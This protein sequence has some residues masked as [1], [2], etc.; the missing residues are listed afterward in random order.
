MKDIAIIGI[1]LTLPY[2][3][4]LE[5]FWEILRSGVDCL[6]EMPVHRQFDVEQ[7]Y[8]AYEQDCSEYDIPMGAYL[9]HVDFF[10][11]QFFGMNYDEAVLLEPA[12]RLLFQTTWKAIEDAGY[13]KA[14]ISNTDTAIYLGCSNSEEY[15]GF[16]ML[17]HQY[18]LYR[19]VDAESISD[20]FHWSGISVKIN[21][22]C[23][24]S[25]VAVHQACQALSNGEANMAIAGGIRLSLLP[26]KYTKIGVESDDGITR[27]FDSKA[28]GCGGGEGVITILLKEFEQAKRDKDYIHAVIKGS[29]CNQDGATISL[30]APNRE[31]QTQVIRSA[32][33]NAGI[34][35]ETITYIEAHGTGTELGDVVEVEGI[36]KAF[37]EHT[38]CRQ[39][40]GIGSVKSNYGHMEAAAGLLGLVKAVLVLKNKI[41]PPTLHFSYPNKNILFPMTPVYV[42]LHNTQWEQENSVYR[43][44]VSSF[45]FTGTNTHVVL[46]RAPEPEHKEEPLSV[47]LLTISAKD[48]AVLD[49]HILNYINLNYENRS[50]TDICYTANA[51]RE[52]YNYRLA[53]IFKNK[54]DLI[55]KLICCLE[56]GNSLEKEK[57]IYYGY[58]TDQEDVELSWQEI[59]TDKEEL[60]WE[61]I[62]CLYVAGRAVPWKMVYRNIEAKKISLF[63]Y[64]FARNRCWVDAGK[65]KENKVARPYYTLMF[66]ESSVE[67]P[68]KTKVTTV[69]MLLH[70]SDI[71]KQLAEFLKKKGVFVIEVNLSDSFKIYHE[72]SFSCG[73]SEKDFEQL[74]HN[75]TVSDSVSF[76][77]DACYWNKNSTLTENSQVLTDGLRYL[78]NFVKVLGRQQIGK[79]MLNIVTSNTFTVDGRAQ[80]YEGGNAA[81]IGFGKAIQGE[82]HTITC[83]CIDTDEDFHAI[84]K[85]LRT[86]S[87][88]YLAVYRKGKRYIQFIDRRH[89]HNGKPYEFKA[90][91]VYLLAGGLGNIGINIANAISYWGAKHIA[92]IS[93]RTL[94]ERSNWERILQGSEQYDS[95]DIQV[96]RR[97]FEIEKLG[98]R[99]HLYS[100]D[101]THLGRVDEIIKDCVSKFGKIN[102]IFQCTGV[103][104]GKNG[105]SISMGNDIM[106]HNSIASKITGTCNM[107]EAA[108]RFTYDFFMALSS[109]ISVTGGVNSSGYIAANAFLDTLADYGQNRN[110]NILVLSLAPYEKTIRQYDTEFNQEM[111]LFQSMDTRS[112][113]RALEDALA[114]PGGY[115][116]AGKLNYGSKLFQMKEILPFRFS[117]EILEENNRYEEQ[118]GGDEKKQEVRQIQITG[119]EA[120]SLNE[121]DRKIIYILCSYLGYEKISL[122][123][124]FYETGGDSLIALKVISH[125]NDALGIHAVVSDL[126][127]NPEIY[128]FLHTLQEKYILSSEK[129]I[130]QKTESGQEEYYPVSSPQKRLFLLSQRE[131]AV[132][133]WNICYVMEVTKGKLRKERLEDA[134]KN[135]IRRHESLR[136]SFHLRKGK[137]VQKIH[138][139]IDFSVQFVDG[140]SD[141]NPYLSLLTEP[142]HLGKPPLLRAMVVT[143]VE[144][145][146]F[147]LFSLHHIISDEITMGIIVRELTALYQGEKL[148][149][150]YA[151]YKEFALLQQREFQAGGYQREENYWLQVF[152]DRLSS[153]RLESMYDGTGKNPSEG[154][155]IHFQLPKDISCQIKEYA[156][157]YNAMSYWY[158]M[159]VFQVLLS[160]HI[161]SQDVVTGVTTTGRHYMHFDNTVGMF[162]NVLPLRTFVDKSLSFHEL[163]LAVKEKII[164][165]YEHQKYPYDKLVEVVQKKYGYLLEV[166]ISFQM[167]KLLFEDMEFTKEFKLKLCDYPYKAS[168]QDILLEFYERDSQL[169]FD[170]T[171]STAKFARTT[172]ETFIEEF[173]SLI[174]KVL[175]NPSI[176]VQKLTENIVGI[177]GSN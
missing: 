28:A 133:G 50:L 66:K 64:S 102:G 177:S 51:C 56:R 57:G 176:T 73:Q 4:N 94:P 84:W 156:K 113:L 53:I 161:N 132:S 11:Y 39:F 14:D 112:I 172:M 44:G 97:L 36:T 109:P 12:Q 154:D 78:Y 31:A 87:E 95:K 134:F 138:D 171:Y 85:E 99:I 52:H 37:E 174:Q 30:S 21:T 19:P 43:C 130:F 139:K 33:K 122:A 2:A 25:L 60:L 46:E 23:S 62:A 75:I 157:N 137:V 136:T 170:L 141:L 79:C 68:L 63:P 140:V 120:D 98:S 6:R 143:T 58:V 29:A 41:I 90:E 162:V 93:R 47:C 61:R 27:P 96:I 147:F 1:G 175:R 32:W 169:I 9:E 148:S 26:L 71:G 158:L 151:Q 106:L 110:K 153:Q 20:Y 149:E 165:A 173:L 91:G 86:V 82:Y 38:M 80:N 104:V 49:R 5:E 163:M 159:A 124:N 70:G 77:F 3:E 81:F 107:L 150:E 145:K 144:D 105:T 65:S 108:N 167:H 15:K 8:Q 35:P 127:N 115:M 123:D 16:G 69:V 125:I 101:I 54:E 121:T 131:Y 128:Q 168:N 166:N 111:H 7:Y 88:D 17:S 126:L 155:R 10:D 72:S 59:I 114:Q 100:G 48:R 24:S 42:N 103:G 83:K 67:E 55:N 160:K 129:T 146:S 18:P 89:G 116:L 164:A 119:E 142:F 34:D 152:A 13:T 45:G 117:L 40:C 92:I 135:L 74:F 22:V 76:L 118:R